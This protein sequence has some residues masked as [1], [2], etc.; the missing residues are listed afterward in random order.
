MIFLLLMP[1][2]GDY[3]EHFKCE[4]TEMRKW[5]LAGPLQ[6]EKRE[7]HISSATFSL[8]KSFPAIIE[9]EVFSSIAEPLAVF[10]LSFSV[11][12]SPF[13]IPSGN[14]PSW[15]AYTGEGPSAQ[16]QV[17]EDVDCH[18][19]G[20]ILCVVYSSTSEIMGAECLTSVFIVVNHTKCN[21]QIYKRDTIMFF[22]DEDWKNVISNLGPGDDVEIFV[23]F[24]HG[25]IVKQTAVYLIYGHS[26]TMEIKHSITMEVETSTN[27]EMKP[28]EEVNEQ[29]S[30]EVDVEASITMEVEPSTNMEMEPLAEVNVQSLPEM[31]MQ[32]SPEVKVE[33]STNV[34]TDLSQEV[35]MQSLPI[36]E[37]EPPPK[38][39]RSI[40]TR[41]AKKNGCMF[42]LEPA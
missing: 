4:W 7:W 35:K 6:V 12:Y 26:I 2:S 30:P 39:N 9:A 1:Q 42:M 5:P 13:G 3:N 32:Q 8:N 36:M 11:T 17:P 27:M 19:K 34:K 16:F 22:N 20:I 14:H 33:A 40:F 15:L 28:S 18:I 31:E 29:L 10:T 24:G 41:F 23:A 21:I 25:L 38:S 37:M